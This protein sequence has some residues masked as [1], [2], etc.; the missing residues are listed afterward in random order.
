MRRVMSM[1]LRDAG[2]SVLETGNG[3][4]AVQILADR[5]PILVITDV[6]MPDMDG[7]ETIRAIRDA[8]CAIK[9]L[10]TSG[11]GIARR[12][13]FLEVASEFGAD[14]VLK[15]PFSIAEL[16]AAVRQL[17]PEAAPFRKPG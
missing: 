6:L 8:G 14:M 10:A 7:I 1:A 12:L 16:M 15:K 2:F 11:G 4:E 17:A 3:R 9:I 13:E 5:Q